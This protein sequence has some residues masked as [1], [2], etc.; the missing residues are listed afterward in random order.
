MRRFV[1]AMQRDYPLLLFA[2]CAIV[3]AFA[4]APRGGGAAQ[5]AKLD[6]VVP[7][8]FYPAGAGGNDWNKLN[9]AAS[10]VPLTAIMNPGNGPGN[11]VDSN[12]VSVVNALRAAGGHVI[13]YVYSSYS[14]RSLQVVLDDVDRYDSFYNVDGIFVDEMANI[15]PAE[16]LNY[17]KSIYDYAKSIDSTWQ[18]MGNPGTQTLEAY[19]TWPTAD[20]LM[21]QENVGSAYPNYMPSSWNYDY[22][23]SSFVHLVHTEPSSTNMLADLQLAIQYHASGIYVTDDI[24]ANPWDRLPTYW[25]SLVEAVAAIN[26]DYNG[27]GAVDAGDYTVWRDSVGLTG[28]GLAADG[29]GDGIVDSKDY[30]HWKNYFGA[31]AGGGAGGAATVRGVAAPEP[32][33]AIYFFALLILKLGVG[34]EL[35]Y[36][37]KG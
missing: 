23:P 16:R 31:S 20:R 18:V 33:S 2:S 6:I 12:Y 9:S 8:Y 24:L 4:I 26:A 27:D 15:G 37:G 22:D 30:A 11:S 32:A 1:R 36:S 21:V 14:A 34:R 28:S 10:K 13:G 5:A 29:N 25:N 35:L 17:Y 3:L 19:L 7:A